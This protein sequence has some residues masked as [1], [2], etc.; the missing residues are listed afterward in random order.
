MGESEFSIDK[1][2]RRFREKDFNFIKY[3]KY[4]F[5]DWMGSIGIKLNW[6]I[7]QKID[8]ILV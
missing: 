4:S 5:Y 1:T 3:M 7:D 8:Q 2:G 6:E